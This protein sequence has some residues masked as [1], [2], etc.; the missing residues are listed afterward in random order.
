MFL[1]D[2]T[3]KAQGDGECHPTPENCETLHLKAGET[4]FFDTVDA[5]GVSTGSGFQLDLIKIHKPKSSD[6][7]QA[8]RSAGLARMTKAVTP[9]AGFGDVSLRSRGLG[10][11][12]R[13]G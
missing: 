11:I 8:A 1:L 10:A 13:T 6:D 5:T 2:S 4:E 9:A 12:G 7:D 3:I